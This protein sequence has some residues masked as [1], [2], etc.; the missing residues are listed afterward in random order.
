MEDNLQQQLQLSIT[1][2]NT[3]T[4]LSIKP[5]A[6]NARTPVDLCCVVDVSGSMAS[7]AT[8]KSITGDVESYSLSVLDVVKHSVKT[9][10]HNLQDN[11]RLSIVTFETRGKVIFSLTTMDDKGR[12]KALDEV[13]K[14]VTGG[15][16]NMWEGLELGLD[17]MVKQAAIKEKNTA[18]LLLT[19]GM[20]D[21]NPQGYL[22]LLRGYKEKKT[23]ACSIHTFGFGYSL[24]SVLLN[25]IAVEGNGS[26]AFIPDS[27]LVGTVFVNALTNLLTTCAT[28]VTLTLEPIN[29]AVIPTNGILGGHRVTTTPQGQHVISLGAVKFDQ[30]TDVVTLLT[31]PKEAKPYLRA[32]LAY[33]NLNTKCPGNVVVEGVHQGDDKN[34]QVQKF[35]L[36]FVDCL[37][38]VMPKAKE[39]KSTDTLK[40]VNDLVK[41]IETSSVKDDPFLLDLL[42]DLQGQTTEALEN[43]DAFKRWGQHFLPSLLCAHLNQQCNNF[44]DFGVQHY[45]K[46]LF[47]RIRDEI[48]DTFL[49]I[50]PPVPTKKNAAP[51]NMAVYYNAGG[52]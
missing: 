15:G 23:F 51:V 6:G 35:R 27:S 26:Y 8:L 36:L 31:L 48:D 24:D 40:Y 25:D 32:T 46:E 13:E 14:L 4:L 39:G 52:G 21:S 34:I 5:P 50:P 37:R 11:D 30:S 42:K 9:I 22:N 2:N 18:L 28:N 44:K 16:T 1:A 10:I 45:A 3:H 47:T 19:D 12:K 17:E 38:N 33:T 7:E 41:E 20:P 29:G 49:K 43:V